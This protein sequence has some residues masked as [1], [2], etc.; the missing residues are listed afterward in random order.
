M[1]LVKEIRWGFIHPTFSP[2]KKKKE[3]VVRDQRDL[4][5]TGSEGT[6][7]SCNQPQLKTF[8]THKPCLQNFRTAFKLCKGQ[9]QGAR[10]ASSRS[11]CGN[12]SFPYLVMPNPPQE[13]SQ[14]ANT[15]NPLL[16]PSSGSLFPRSFGKVRI[17]LMFLGLLHFHWRLWSWAPG[18]ANLLCF[19]QG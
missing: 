12:S 19:R 4:Q 1:H 15:S 16:A 2:L 14:G 18:K 13:P 7:S 8:P 3:N 5:D 10:A 17:F 6:Q 9:I 11:G